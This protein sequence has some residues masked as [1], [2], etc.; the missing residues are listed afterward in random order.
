LPAVKQLYEQLSSDRRYG[1][2]GLVIGVVALFLSIATWALVG[3]IP[4]TQRRLLAATHWVGSG[5]VLAVA[6]ACFGMGLSFCGLLVYGQR[7]TEA[8][9]RLRSAPPSTKRWQRLLPLDPSFRAATLGFAFNVL[10]LLLF[11]WM[12]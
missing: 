10:A 9:L 6:L 11:Y 8:R 1:V 2:L 12:F 4:V 7:E 3:R 5:V